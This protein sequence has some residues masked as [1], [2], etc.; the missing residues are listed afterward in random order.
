MSKVTGPG[1][2]SQPVSN[3][4]VESAQGTNLQS[5]NEPSQQTSDS[6]SSGPVRLGS[7]DAGRRLVEHRVEGQARQAELNA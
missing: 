2:T 5:V 1:G 7:R 4:P 3:Q 6:Q